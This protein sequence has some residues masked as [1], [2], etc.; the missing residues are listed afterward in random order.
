MTIYSHPA[1]DV[2]GEE[3]EIGL[4][5]RCNGKGRRGLFRRE[6]QECGGTGKVWFCGTFDC[7]WE[8]EVLTLPSQPTAAPAYNPPNVNPYFQQMLTGQFGHTGRKF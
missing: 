1:C 6:C 7:G 3:L 2:C 5:C 8:D 4:C